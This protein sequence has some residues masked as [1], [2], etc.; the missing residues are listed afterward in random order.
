MENLRLLRE[1]YSPVLDSDA[2][3]SEEKATFEIYL[4]EAFATLIQIIH[5][6]K[7][8][9]TRTMSVQLAERF[10]QEETDA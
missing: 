8:I 3:V 5:K 1:R 9:D 7:L 10:G 6:E 4:Y 2:Y